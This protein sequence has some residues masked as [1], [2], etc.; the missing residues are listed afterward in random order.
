MSARTKIVVQVIALSVAIG[1]I[2]WHTVSWHISGMNSM[3]YGYLKEG[4]GYIT[5]L[6]NMGLLV[7]T[8]SLIGLLMRKISEISKHNDP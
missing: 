7:V 1:L 8:G 3:I 5:V 6:Y 2:I 4:K